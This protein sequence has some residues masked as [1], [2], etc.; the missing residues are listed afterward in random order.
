MIRIKNLDFGYPRSPFRLRI[1]DAHVAEGEKLC[2]TGPSGSGKTT[3]VNI[4]SGILKPASGT[5][6]VA[7]R[8]ISRKNDRHNR[9]FRLTNIGFIFQNFE[10]LD[11]LSVEG[12]ILLAYAIGRKM[13]VDAALRER[14]AEV[15]ERMGIA[16]KR[17]AFPKHLSQGEKQRVAICRAVI[18]NPRIIVADEP[19][20]NLDVENRTRVMD[21]IGEVLD[22][23]RSTFLMVTHDPALYGFFDRRLDLGE[24]S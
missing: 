23:N 24:A 13:K 11:Y 18:A 3:L 20:A 15:T 1:T 6:E 10:L 12:N 2:I 14:L 22:R 4:I 5:V 17:R 9:E 19:T 21:L 16:D 8:E 7:G